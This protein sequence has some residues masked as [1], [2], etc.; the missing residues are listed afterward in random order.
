M[1]VEATYVAP[2]QT[3]YVEVTTEQAVGPGDE[4]GIVTPVEATMASKSCDLLECLWTG[5]NKFTVE[6]NNCGLTLE[7]GQQVGI[8]EPITVVPAED[9]LW[10]DTQVLL[11]QTSDNDTV[12]RRE[13]LVEKLQY[14]EDLAV[15]DKQMLEQILVYHSDVFALTDDELG[16]TNLV[17][18]HIDIGD[19]K[20]VKAL[21]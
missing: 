6:L 10:T 15:G 1:L 9:P 11:C 13:K 18:H 8:V 14:G 17:T 4:V 7:K 5:K 19:A 16:E 2:G 12:T 20:P 21:P 3:R